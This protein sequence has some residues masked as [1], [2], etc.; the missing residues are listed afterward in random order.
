MVAARRVGSSQPVRQKGGAVLSTIWDLKYALRLLLK[1]PWFTLLTVLVLAG[2]LGISLYTFAVLNTM[3]YRDLPVPEGQAIVRIGLGDWP[4]VVPLDA[5][6][7]ARILPA[8]HNITEGGAYRTTRALVGEPGS[9]RSLRVIESDWRIFETS[10]TPPML[11]R[12]F[13]RDDGSA[14]GEPV[15]VLSYK[16]WQSVF[17]ASAAAVGTLVKI[18]GRVTRIVGVMPEG[19]AFPFNSELWLPLSPRELDP[20]GYTGIPLDAYARLSP[21]VSSDA[22]A[23]E[24]TSLLAHVRESR[25]SA[26]ELNVGAVSVM[27][28]QRRSWGNL[29]TIVFVVLNLLSFTI[30]LLAAINVGNLLLARTNERMK[31]IGVRIALGGPRLRLVSQVMLENLLLCS[32]GGV[33]AI[34]VA[35]RMLGA[36]NGFMRA[37]FGGDAPFWW[38]WGLDR[39]FVMAAGLFLLLTVVLVSVLPAVSVSRVDPNMLLRGGTRAGRGLGVGRVSRA[40][41]TAQVASIS[42]VMV[43]GGVVTVIAHRAA[44][45]DLGFD[46]ADLLTMSVAPPGEKYRTSEERVS[47]YERLLEELRGQ[48]GVEA[49]GVMQERYGGRF[50]VEGREYRDARDYATAWHVVLSTVALPFGPKLIAGRTFDDRDSAKG[51]K[52]AIVSESLAR[53]YWPNESAIGRRI[54]VAFGAAELEPRIV[55]GVM[56]DVRYDPV[57]R[58]STG[59]VAVYVPLPQFVAPDTRVVVRSSGDPTRASSAMYEALARLDPTVPADTVRSYSS[60]L[61]QVTLFARTATSLFAA[62]GAFAILIAIAGIYGM[63]SNAVVLRRHEIGLRRALGASNGN[64]IAAFVLQGARQL[65]IALGASA[66]LSAAALFLILQAFSVGVWT[67]GLVGTAVVLVVSLVVLLSIF[68]SVHRAIRLEPG[69]ALRVQ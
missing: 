38:A 25:V 28:F 49:V 42:A 1:R 41:V 13:V 57:G 31:E 53:A 56:S 4:T 59:A 14:G 47:F 50:A 34:L 40:L 7:L 19:Y 60:M 5:Y 46:V 27:S 66:V 51:Q 24:L 3:V 22:A 69:T 37:L 65:A 35:A 20:M 67:L 68:L 39:D 8:A 33:I 10:R 58:I 23:T 30:L 12:G 36:T 64:V 15:A 43:I 44:L 6:E 29:G 32:L 18:N 17:S 9:S 55:V 21:G 16:T 11:G 45:F 26:D 48:R 54:D 2:G 62:C 61:D 52:T 63:S